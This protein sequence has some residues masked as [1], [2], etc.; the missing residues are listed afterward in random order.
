MAWAVGIDSIVQHNLVVAAA[1]FQGIGNTFNILTIDPG[2]DFISR[3]GQIGKIE[4][5]PACH[6]LETFPAD[7]APFCR[8]E[9]QRLYA[10]SLCRRK[11]DM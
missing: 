11:D 4:L 2:I 5:V 6:Y 7:F 8:L 10:A 3:K 9:M 1:V